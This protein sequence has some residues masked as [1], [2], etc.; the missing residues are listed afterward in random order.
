MTEYALTPPATP[1]VAVDGES[2]RFDRLGEIN[3]EIGKASPGRVG[4]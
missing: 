1:F 3:I 2:A 4:T